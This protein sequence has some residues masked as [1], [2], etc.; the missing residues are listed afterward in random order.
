MIHVAVIGHT[1]REAQAVDLADSL[2]AAL[3]LDR[4]TLGST[5][6]H[7]RALNWGAAQDGHLI[8]LEDDAIPVPGFIAL[9]TDFIDQHPEDLTSFYLGHD[10]RHHQRLIPGWLEQ[11][12]REGR[13]HITHPSLLH[14]VAYAIPCA[15][16]PQLNY[17]ATRFAADE[18]I[19]HAWKPTRRPVLYTIP[20]LV[21]HQDGPSIE[22]RDRRQPGR[23]AWRPH[24]G[25]QRPRMPHTH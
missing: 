25:L 18:M 9:A 16:I 8:V 15:K 3:F 2:H 22:N 11:A 19:T 1:S 6:N 14:A 5:W 17:R 12:D 13:D 10:S 23:T 24:E 4:L 21:D 20:S 7:L